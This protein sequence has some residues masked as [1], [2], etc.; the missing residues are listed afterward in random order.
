MGG[1]PSG[2]PTGEPSGEHRA[3][4]N[5]GGRGGHVSS[6]WN[7]HHGRS[8]SVSWLSIVIGAVL[9]VVCIVHVVTDIASL[10]V[11]IQVLKLTSTG[12]CRFGNNNN[13]V[14]TAAGT[15]NDEPTPA[16]STAAAS[17]SKPAPPTISNASINSSV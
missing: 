15:G 11:G 10:V 1:A 5:R 17:S 6:T 14:V 13:N 12:C 16:Y 4:G 2:E 3:G 8:W 7:D 9:A